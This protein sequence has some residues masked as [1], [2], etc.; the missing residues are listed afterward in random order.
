VAETVPV[1]I[2]NRGDNTADSTLCIFLPN[3][4][5]MDVVVGV[6]E[7]EAFSCCGVGLSTGCCHIGNLA[8]D[9]PSPMLR[10]NIPP[11]NA[12]PAGNTEPILGLK[13]IAISCW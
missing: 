4:R 13:Y 7:G 10:G 9:E 1:I 5:K 11:E 6:V 8:T 3:L 2:D 12:V